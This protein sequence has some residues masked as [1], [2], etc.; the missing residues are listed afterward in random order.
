M[1]SLVLLERYRLDDSN[2]IKK[3]HK[4]WP[5]WVIPAVQ[6]QVNPNIF[7]RLV[8]PNSSIVCDLFWCRLTRFIEIFQTILMVSSSW[9]RWSLFIEIFI[10]IQLCY[11]QS[12]MYA[13]EQVYQRCIFQFLL[14]FEISCQCQ[15]LLYMAYQQ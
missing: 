6:R 5:Q 1:I 11:Y 4:Q 15:N 8:W 12:F 9:C 2:D 14:K 7:G 3:G 13:R 10:M